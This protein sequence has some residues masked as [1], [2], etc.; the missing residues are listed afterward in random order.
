MKVLVADIL[1]KIPKLPLDVESLVKLRQLSTGRADVRSFRGEQ[2]DGTPP[3]WYVV[4]IRPHK[5]D[6]GDKSVLDATCGCVAHKLCHHITAMYAVA[7]AGDPAVIA[8]MAQRGG[9]QEAAECDTVL[10][11]AVLAK[12]A[13]LSAH[14]RG[15]AMIAESQRL[16]ALAA[17]ALASGIWLMVQGD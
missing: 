1:A 2:L 12:R 6:P 17:Q 5:D 3:A 8:A 14:G 15:L 11:E 9:P 7:K 16:F 13:P 10:V 4:S